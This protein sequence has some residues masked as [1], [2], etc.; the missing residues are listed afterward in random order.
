MSIYEGLEA[1]PLSARSSEMSGKDGRFTKLSD[2]RDQ[3]ATDGV[4]PAE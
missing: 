3:S 2:F 4:L 1:G